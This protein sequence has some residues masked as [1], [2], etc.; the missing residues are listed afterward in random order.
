MEKILKIVA[1]KVIL[2]KRP[3]RCNERKKYYIPLA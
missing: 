2:A 3:V 1:V